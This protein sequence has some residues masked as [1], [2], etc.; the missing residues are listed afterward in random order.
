MIST[1]HQTK[2]SI[3]FLVRLHSYRGMVRIL[4][5]GILVTTKLYII[6]RFSLSTLICVFAGSFRVSLFID[7][8]FP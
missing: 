7:L 5:E 6:L 4:L 2:L 1:L 3:N 8:G